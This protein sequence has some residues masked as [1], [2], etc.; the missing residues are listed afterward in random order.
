MVMKP[1]AST[2]QSWT[3]AF[4]PLKSSTAKSLEL[5]HPRLLSLGPV[6]IKFCHEFGNET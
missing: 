6:E 2:Q 4:P 3:K 5:T 1:N